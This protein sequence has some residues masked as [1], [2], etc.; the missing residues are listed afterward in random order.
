MKIGQPERAQFV[1]AFVA[2]YRFGP[3]ALFGRNERHRSLGR[4]A[5]MLRTAAGGQ[6]EVDF[7]AS[8]RVT[9]MS[10]QKKTLLLLNHTATFMNRDE[11][12]VYFTGQFGQGVVLTP[13]RG[14]SRLLLQD[15]VTVRQSIASSPSNPCLACLRRPMRGRIRARGGRPGGVSVPPIGASGARNVNRRGPVK[16]CGGGIRAGIH[17]AA[18]LR[19]SA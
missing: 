18:G 19:R 7:C 5:Q 2:Q 1:L 13:L 14:R 8:R 9:P 6:P 3:L 15:V 17:D 4:Q 12:S 11:L 16:A 10:G